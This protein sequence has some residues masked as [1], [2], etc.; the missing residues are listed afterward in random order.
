MLVNSRI[1]VSNGCA[2]AGVFLL[3]LASISPP[4]WYPTVPLF[5]GLLLVCISHFLTPCQDQ[6]T[7][8]WRSRIS[9]DQK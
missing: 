4:G 8:W 5:A 3:I 2:V 6:I 9:K 7:R 1:K